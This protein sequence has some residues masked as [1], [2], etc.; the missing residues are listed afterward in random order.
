MGRLSREHHE[1]QKKQSNFSLQDETVQKR[2]KICQGLLDSILKTRSGIR[3]NK[4]K[5]ELKNVHE[6]LCCQA[7]SHEQLK[8]R[9]AALEAKYAQSERKKADLSDRL[10][11][12]DFHRKDTEKKFSNRLQK[13]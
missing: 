2:L 3:K 13:N 7:E 4:Y 5:N 1:M 10:V 11:R 8:K 9:Y 12:L 6:Y